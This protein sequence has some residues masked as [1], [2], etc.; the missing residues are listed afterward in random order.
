MI[1]G[2]GLWLIFLLLLKTQAILLKIISFQN[3]PYAALLFG[4]AHRTLRNE[5]KLILTLINYF[6]LFRYYSYKAYSSYYII[7]FI[8]NGE[9]IVQICR[10]N[11]CGGLG[12]TAGRVWA[13]NGQMIDFSIK[14]LGFFLCGPF[15]KFLITLYDWF[16]HDDY[17]VALAT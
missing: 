9:G 13:V 2:V 7:W 4:Q 1:L 6:V 14:G 12:Q 10:V 17:P 15:L 3:S 8:L 16:K 5:I 11:P